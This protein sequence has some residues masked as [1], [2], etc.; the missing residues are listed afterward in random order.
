MAFVK[1]LEG[2]LK[3]ETL[4]RNQWQFQNPL[5]ER[6]GNSN[7]TGMEGEG[8]VE[9]IWGGGGDYHKAVFS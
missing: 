3:C 8:R 1:E 6:F 9:R 5:Q 7:F 2:P 4:Y